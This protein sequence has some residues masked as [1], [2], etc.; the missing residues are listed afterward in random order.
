MEIKYWFDKDTNT[1]TYCVYDAV[2]KDAVVIDSVWNFDQASGTLK[3]TAVELVKDF[4]EA[5]ALTLHYILETH[6]HADHVTGAQ[7]LKKIFPEAKIGA[8]KRILDVQKVFKTVL[9][10]G[11]KFAVD[12][13]Q[14]DALFDDGQDF[15]AGNLTLKVIATPG[16]TPAC[17]SYLIGDAVFVGDA[18]FMPDYGTG[19]CDFPD[20]NAEALF[21]SIQKLYALPDSTRVFT[22]H[23]YMPNGRPTAWE[24]TI[25]SQKRDNIQLKCE[26]TKEQ[27][28]TLRQARDKT[29]TAPKLL[30]PSIQ[31]NIAAGHLPM[32]EEQG[33]SFLKLP[34]TVIEL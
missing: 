11:E 33:Q 9:N 18:L 13:R 8:G 14:F 29:L 19:R 23:D 3:K 25:G 1:F 32:P 20:G 10:L 4:I 2:T 30:F 12:G 6:A 31:I 22:G 5:R 26:T 24:S 15:K 17:V 28:V 16:H 21:N 34:I 27:Y 7:P